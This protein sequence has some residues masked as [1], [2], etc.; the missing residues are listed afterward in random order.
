MSAQSF[1]DAAAPL[2]SVTEKHPFLVSMV[3]GSLNLDKFK[4]YAIQDAYYLTDFANCL[5]RLGD[6]ILAE[7]GNVE[8]SKR[9][10]QFG[11]TA[12]EDEKELHRSFF[13][14][15]NIDDTDSQVMPNTLLYTSYMLRIVATRPI[16]E[17][18]SVLLPC[19]WVYH[20]V[21]KCMLK[22]RDQLG[23][24]VS[25]P[26]AFDAWIDMYSGDEFENEVKEYI[27]IVDAVA[28]KADSKTL[29]KMEEH[30]IMSCRLE[31]MFWD[32]AENLMQ[33]SSFTTSSTD[34]ETK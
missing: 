33:W 15:W 19:Y 22:L 26:P 14:Q 28:K 20:Y 7:E 27:A 8:L 17:G 23:D 24:T 4:Y 25:R 16:A 12:E 1:W 32:Q 3:D 6:R 31:H 29:K 18:L 11:K 21:G 9:L 2:I 34:D 13:K 10:H 5:G 30:F